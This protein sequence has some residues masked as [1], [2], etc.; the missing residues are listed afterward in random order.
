LI[1]RAL[2][3]LLGIVLTAAVGA[4]VSAF[5][6]LLGL[7]T[8]PSRVWNWL[9]PPAQSICSK[10]VPYDIGTK[11][12]I[13][14]GA[15][16]IMQT[17]M[18]P[19]WKDGLRFENSI[20]NAIRDPANNKNYV[21]DLKTYRQKMT[22]GHEKIETLREGYPQYDDIDRLLQQPY[23]DQFSKAINGYIGAYYDLRPLGS[24]LTMSAIK[25]WNDAFQQGVSEFEQWLHTTEKDVISCRK[26]L[27][28]PDPQQGLG[29]GISGSARIRPGQKQARQIG[30]VGVAAVLN[31]RPVL[32][33]R[34]V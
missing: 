22:T 9:A 25:P 23:Y 30:A 17:D 2:K 26:L 34:T 4:S 32:S 29:T 7:N 5:F 24:N 1:G 10:A 13:L 27:A 12:H 18:E 16:Q 15:L 28:R 6:G 3:W 20:W 14:D 8:L 11:L 21:V 31:L 19:V 33:R